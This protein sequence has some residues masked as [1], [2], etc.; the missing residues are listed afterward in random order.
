MFTLAAP[1]VILAY[2]TYVFVA[3][4]VAGLADRVSLSNMQTLVSDTYSYKVHV[5]R[6]NRDG[7][8]SVAIEG[9]RKGEYPEGTAPD[10]VTLADTT[11]VDLANGAFITLGETTSFDIPGYGTV[12]ATPG[13]SGVN[14]TF[15][16]GD[17]PEWINASKNRVA[18]TADGARLTITRNR[19]EVFRYFYGWELFFFTLDSPFHGKSVTELLSSGQYG[20]IWSDFWSNKMWRHADVAWALFETV[21][22]AF[23]GTF[24]AAMIALPLGFLAAKNFTPL[25]SL[26]FA[27]RRVFDFLRGVDGLIWTIVLSRAFGPGPLTGSLAIMLTDTGTFGKIFS[28]ALENVDDKQI[29]GIA[30]TGAKPLQRYR[31]GVIPQITP[32]LLSQVLYYLESNT[33][34]ATIIGAITGGGIGLMLTQA[35]IT[36]KD[37]EEVSYYIILIILMVMAMDS[38][39]GWLRRRLIQGTGEG[40]H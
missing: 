20:A 27:A 22:M 12:T 26:R 31:F 6:D 40:T 11:R 13:R 36:Q 8:T 4:D 25:G 9:E 23:L 5:T 21:L 34:S 38:F 35:I 7:A 15:P 1:A 2:L 28:E 33:R 37:W 32:V 39:S 19:T 16:P 24:G 10:W 18:I 30:S 29:E 17:L 14:A 3:F